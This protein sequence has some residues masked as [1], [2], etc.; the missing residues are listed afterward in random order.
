V[1]LKAFGD[2]GGCHCSTRALTM[3][4]VIEREV[5]AQCTAY[6]VLNVISMGV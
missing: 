6:K 2:I 5:T 4:I 1:R 3:I